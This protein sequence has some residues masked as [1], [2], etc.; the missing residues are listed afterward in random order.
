MI[1]TEKIIINGRELV[2]TYSNTGHMIRQDGTGA[3]YSEAVD[4]IETGR[5]YTETDDF[6]PGNELTAEEALNII[7]WVSE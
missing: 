7:T 5:T 4:P 2:R 3:I 1:Q 6:V